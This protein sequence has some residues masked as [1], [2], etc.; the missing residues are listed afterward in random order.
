MPV[1][2]HKPLCVLARRM[3]VVNRYASSHALLNGSLG[4]DLNL[5]GTKR[6]EI[7]RPMPSRRRFNVSSYVKKLADVS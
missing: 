7:S 5:S 2:T 6:F 4:L 3:L 1:L